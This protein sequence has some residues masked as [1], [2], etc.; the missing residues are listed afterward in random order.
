MHQEKWKKD[1]E[2]CALI[3]DLL[4]YEEVQ[5]LVNY[6]HH[7]TTNRLDH[8][9]SV[10]YRSYLVAKK[11]DLDTR[12]VA[13]AGLLHDLFYFDWR[14]TKFDEGTHAFVHP[15]IACQNAE[16]L[17]ELSD[18]ERDII[19]KHMWLATVAFPKYKESYIVSLVDKYCAITEVL[20]PVKA[21][22]ASW[23]NGGKERVRVT[24]K[25]Q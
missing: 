22:I 11:L 19:I 14:T 3:E 18:L 4:Q 12:A 21:K 7:Y 17:T 15:H 8:S 2:Y 24:S 13:R 23:F 16:K 20:S 9:L 6:T 10:S 25:T 1:S 5:T